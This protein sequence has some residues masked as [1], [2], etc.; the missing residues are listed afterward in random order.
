M[1]FRWE[2]L[3]QTNAVRFDVNSVTLDLGNMG[4][5]GEYSDTLTRPRQMQF[6]AAT[7]SR[8][9]TKEGP[10][11]HPPCVAVRAGVQLRQVVRN[12]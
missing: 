4:S 11:A 3:N 5:F 7:I 9:L 8:L 2:T 1:Q 6:A 12:D 10:L